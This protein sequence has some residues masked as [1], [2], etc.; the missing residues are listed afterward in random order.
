MWQ[1]IAVKLLFYLTVFI[2]LIML[3]LLYFQPIEKI[4]SVCKELRDQGLNTFSFPIAV[5]ATFTIN[6]VNQTLALI[7]ALADNKEPVRLH[8][9][10]PVLISASK[11]GDKAGNHCYKFY[12]L[13][14]T[15]WLAAG[16]FG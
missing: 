6:N 7:Q 15:G 13:P 9:F 4:V 14:S 16:N 3:L 10:W 12:F 5:Q 8:Y 11:S 1:Y 2:N